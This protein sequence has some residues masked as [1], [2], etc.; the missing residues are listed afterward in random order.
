MNKLPKPFL[1]D[2]NPLNLHKD[3]CEK[4]HLNYL[5]PNYWLTWLLI[6]ISFF[7]TYF[8]HSFRMMLGSLLGKFIYLINK[9]RRNIAK[10]NISLCFK[11]ITKKESERILTKYFSWLG[12]TFLDM[13]TLWWKN[14]KSLQKICDIENIKYL[15]NELKKNKGVVL[16]TA[17]T[18]SLD[19]G[20][21]SISKF[22]IISMYKPFRNQLLNWF[23]GK[24]RSKNTDNVVVFPREEF[25]FKTVVKSLQSPV[26]FYYVADEDL[27]TQNSI[28]SN[29]FDEPKSTLISICKIASL[30]GA[31]VLPCINHYCPDKQKYITYIDK[32]LEN[33]PSGD[34]KADARTIN[35]S[36]ENLITRQTEQYMW[37]LRLF[38]SRPDGFNFPY[39]K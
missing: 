1:S 19:F 9:K 25:S 23:I 20:G 5:L 24:S 2:K 31:S 26:V 15:E 3:K 29:F 34:V 13:P 7:L 39:E 17:H 27:G 11:N 30:S 32:P 14:N 8:P 35:M 4:F 22:P 21:R 18:V 12:R 10:V 38:Q 37:S 28:F 6:L 16:L 36:L 33:F